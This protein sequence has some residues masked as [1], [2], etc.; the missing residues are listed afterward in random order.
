M[1]SGTTLLATLM[2]DCFRFDFSPA[3]ETHLWYPVAPGSRTACTKYPGDEI[4]VRHV[5][6]YDGDL[7]FIYML[8]DP[9]DVVVSVHGMDRSAYFT[10][11]RHWRESYAAAQPMRSS[12]RFLQ[13]RYEELV[14]D[15]D[16]VQARIMT[17][18]PFLER[19]KAFSEWDGKG[20][21]SSQYDKA[22]RG[23]RKV[24]PSSVGAWRKHKGRL[25]AQID[26]HGDIGDLLI[27]TGYE[28]DTAWLAELDG[29]EPDLRPGKVADRI[30]SG[31]AFRRKLREHLHAGVYLCRRAVRAR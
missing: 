3:G 7:W 24:E 12:Q 27:E 16:A 13:I 31:K 28:R 4:V 6:P 14:A 19:L 10:N 25:R 17:F 1:R 2:S 9:R 26:L 8:R 20:A 15:P 30:S 18:A 29:V 23:A 5:L 21:L 11:L 22:M